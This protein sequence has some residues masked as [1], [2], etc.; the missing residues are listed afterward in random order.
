M[1]VPGLSAGNHTVKVIYNGDDNH[2]VSEAEDNFTVSQDKPSMDINVTDIDYHDT[3]NIEIALPEDATGTV[4]VTVTGDNG[5][6]KTF[7]DVPVGEDGTVRIPVEDLPAGNYNV[8][9]SYSGDEN[10][11]AVNGTAKFSVDK[12]DSTVD[13]DTEDITYGENETIRY[14]VPEDATGTVNIT[15]VGDNGVTKVFTDVSVENGTVGVNVEDLPAGNYN[16]A[17]Q[18]S[19]DDNYNPGTGTSDFTVDKAVPE[20][21]IET[22]D[23]DYNQTEN[24]TVTLPE[25]ATGTVNVTVTDKDGNNGTFTDVPIGEDGTVIIPVEDLPAG[26]YDVTVD[27]SGDDNYSPT[28]GS[29]SFTVDKIDSILDVDTE[30]ISYGDDE[31]IEITLPED[32]TGTVN[33]TVTGD[34]GVSETFIDVPVG[35]DGTVSIPL[36]NLPAGNYEVNVAYSGDNNYNA[37]NASSTFN[38]DKAK[39]NAYAVGTNITYGDDEQITAIV[40]GKNVTGTVTVFIDGEEK[41]IL[42]DV[43][44]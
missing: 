26:D 21:D 20:M 29:G 3:E 40:D 33:V 39:P 23:I 16:V 6:T 15:V 7:N 9:V 42:V 43:L 25:D 27:Y 44:C 22:E 1:N 38:V 8:T 34:N 12:I 37:E 4:N 32:A 30:D 5:I 17:V 13:V 2:N 14:T 11:T 36:E 41:L 19:G 24:I 28:T 10:Y 18:Y 35:E 31:T